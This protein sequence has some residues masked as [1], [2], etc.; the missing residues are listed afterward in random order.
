MVKD[1]KC[2]GI[3]RQ[4]YNATISKE[5]SCRRVLFLCF[6]YILITVRRGSC[7]TQAVTRPF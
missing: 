4:C 6:Y 5:P 3:L 2:V 7:T 1:C